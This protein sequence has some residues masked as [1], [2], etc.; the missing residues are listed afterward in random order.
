MIKEYLGIKPSVSDKTFIA[1]SAEVIGKVSIGDNSSVWYTSVLRGD[2]NTITI[3]EYTNIQ[4]GCVVHVNS[5]SPTEIGN[6]VT[7]GHRSI[8]HGCKIG[9]N[10]LI[11]MGAI[12]LD[13]VVIEDNTI[14]GAGSIVTPNK[15]ICQK[16][17]AIGAPAKVVRTLNDNEIKEIT[18]SAIHYHQ[19]GNNHK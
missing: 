13:G 2:V 7:I 3:G 11:G 14:I 15:I 10:V 16:S 9:N 17:L 8:I 4:D 6:Y 18:N 1:D 12:I 5:D 19:Y